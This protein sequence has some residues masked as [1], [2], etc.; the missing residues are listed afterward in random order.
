MG[1]DIR[2]ADVVAHRGQDEVAIVGEGVENRIG[3]SV[4][5]EGVQREMEIVGIAQFDHGEFEEFV[6]GIAGID[7]VAQIGGDMQ[8][9]DGECR[10]R[11]AVN[12]NVHVMILSDAWGDVK[13]IEASKELN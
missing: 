11:I 13:R 5:V 9:S 2:V 3:A 8:F 12:W 6:E 4:I 10:D 1:S 7:R